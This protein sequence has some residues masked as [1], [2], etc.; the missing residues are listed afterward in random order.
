[1]NFNKAQLGA[2]EHKDGAMLVLA[3]PGSGKTAVITHRTKNLITKHH[4]KPSEILVITFTK[5]A[6]NEMKERFNALMDGERMNV[7]F[8]TFHAVFFTIL[9]YAYRFTSANIADESV[10]YGFIREI[11]SYYRLEYK[12]ENEFIGNL[13][14][15]I[16]LIKNSRIDI[17][18]FYSGVCGEEIFR[19]IYKKYE[20]RLKENGL[21]DFDDMLSY[22]YEL[23]KERPDILALWQN[24]YKYILIDEFQDINRL[25]YEIIKMLAAPQ[26]NLFIVGD[27]DQSIYRFRGSK[28]EI[29]LGF[30][31]DYPDAKRI[32]LD[33]NY[34]CGRYIVETS[35]NLISHNKERFDKKIIAASKSKVPVTFADFENRRDENIFLIR[36]LDKKIKAGAVFSD[37][38][39]LFRTNTQPRQLIEQL[40]SYNIPFKT[41]DNIP[42][43]YEHWIARDLFTYQRIAAGSRDRADFLQIM[44]R[45]KRY[46]SRDSLC[47]ATVAFDEWI[48]LFDEKPWIA[49]RIEKLEYDMKLISRMNPYASINYIRR[50]IGYDD[51]LSEYAEYRSIN[52]EDLFDILDEIQSGAKGFATYEEW[53]EH[54]KEYTK[55]MKL[56]ALSKDSD[57]NAVTLATLHSSKGLE[58]ENVY[59]IDANEGIMP[60]KKAVLEKDIEEE[61]RLFYV[62]MTRAKTSLS[63]YSVK[64]VNDKSAQASRFVRESK[65]TRQNNS[66]DD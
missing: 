38:A 31:K 18:N 44:N 26:N 64:S 55:Q 34:R 8:G 47:D 53:Y 45:P 10:R 12:D 41:K 66:S 49:E 40:M 11:L 25:Q 22:T 7:S 30:E 58:F 54:I 3:G 28:P 27:D 21:I 59:I 51:F 2:I 15:E 63:V 46:L 17:E 48:K 23:F 19:D 14:A 1:M 6:A 37:F 52:K 13:L 56:M 16:S 43:I 35:L 60:Y 65:E 4:V 5:A 62:G 24:K 61:R 42:N 36:D 29:M 32:L 33:T 50:G 9:K 20:T 57:P 39:V